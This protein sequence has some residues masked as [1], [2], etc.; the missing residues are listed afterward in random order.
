MRAILSVSDKTGIDSLGKGLVALGAG[1][2]AT[3]GTRRAL[4]AEGIPVRG[5]DELTG[6][7]EILDGRVKTLHPAL[8]GGL[9]ARRQ[10]AADQAELA[11]HGLEPIGLVAVNLYP[12]EET[13]ARA[14]V[15]LE[16]ALEQIDIGGPSLLRAAA[17][18]HPAVVPL[19]DPSDYGRVLKALGGQE[20]LDPEARR[21]LASKAFRHTAVY[22]SIVAAYL[23]DESAC[24]PTELALGL[25]RVQEL[26]YGENPQ[27]RAAFYAHARPGPPPAGLSSA[28][29]LQGKP[30]SY[31]NILDADAARRVAS[32]FDGMV[33]AIIKHTN[34]CGLALA[35][36]V[37]EA[38]D[39]AL[40]GDP[41]AAFGGIVAVNRPVDSMLA[42]RIVSRFFEILLAPAYDPEALEALASRPDLRVLALPSTPDPGL[43]WRSVAGGFLVQGADCVASDEVRQGR[44]VT[45][46]VPTGAEWSALDFAWRAVAHVKSNAIVLA[47]PSSEPDA[48]AISLVGMGA[49]QPS[50]VAAVEIA[51]RRAGDRA[52]GSV[53]ASDAFFPKADGL[54]LAAR[55]GVSAIVQPGGSKGDPETIAA[56]DEAGLAM[57]FTGL[58]HF[59]H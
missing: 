5:V 10:N 18:N 39:L 2:F 25:R 53:L 45:S 27:Q 19:C 4:E 14:D 54:Q 43:N 41:L 12:F 36:S 49:G 7:P 22:D 23:D 44:V 42:R 20:G 29:Q 6:F 15:T 38:Y 3:G 28:R 17:K 13:V 55:A 26:R 34:P 33:A 35:G 1:L 9:L 8:Y 57:V 56:A 24:W 40:A 47:R 32:S 30:L 52:A 59:L 58:R 37:L 50:R 46:R 31:N 16:G 48:A 51:A 11:A 21:Q